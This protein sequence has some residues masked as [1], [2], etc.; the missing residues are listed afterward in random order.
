MNSHSDLSHDIGTIN[1]VLVL[2]LLFT[3]S[4]QQSHRTDAQNKMRIS[5]K[6]T[7]NNLPA[8][9]KASNKTESFCR[10]LKTHLALTQLI[11]HVLTLYDTV[12]SDVLIIL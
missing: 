5:T 10:R 6:Q 9:I 7:W 4:K 11:T 2:L 8:S 12:M 3:L 1:I